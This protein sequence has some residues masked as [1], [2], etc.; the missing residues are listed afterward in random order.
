MGAGILPTTIHNNTLY[1]L[2][3]KENRFADTPGWSDFGGGT[4]N[5]ESPIETAIREAR[6][7]LT[8]FLGGSSEIKKMITKNGNYPIQFN[9]YT[10]FIFPMVYDE[11]LPR[12]Y[13]NNQNFL[14]EKLDP[15]IIEE[16][17]IFEKSE[18]KWVPI[19]KLSKLKPKFRSY[20]QNV[21]DILLKEKKEIF[22]FIQKSKSN[23]SKTIKIKKNKSNKTKSRRSL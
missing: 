21:I 1:F 19:H 12:Y 14:Q 20:F 11:Y 4:D 17:K 15:K 6:E 18:I 9:N 16:S 8:G 23:K 2:F 22:E 5:N 3:G 7:E 13:N 10:M